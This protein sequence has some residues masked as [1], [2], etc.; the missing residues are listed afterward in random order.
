MS[1]SHL[2]KRHL[3]VPEDCLHV[4]F[5][6]AV[7]P[8]N[9]GLS[10][11]LLD[12]GDSPYFPRIDRPFRVFWKELNS[13][14]TEITLAFRKAGFFRLNIRYF[15]QSPFFVV[16]YN[17]PLQG[18]MD[19]F[20]DCQKESD[21]TSD[22]PKTL[23]GWVFEGDTYEITVPNEV[24]RKE[25]FGMGFES[26]LDPLRLKAKPSEK[27]NPL[28]E[29]KRVDAMKGEEAEIRPFPFEPEIG[30]EMKLL[31]SPPPSSAFRGVKRYTFY[32]G[33]EDSVPPTVFDYES[34]IKDSK[35]HLT[36]NFHI[37]GFFS[38]GESRSS[39]KKEGDW[40]FNEGLISLKKVGDQKTRILPVTQGQR[41]L[42]SLDIT[43]EILDP[44]WSLRLQ[45][46]PQ[47]PAFF[48]SLREAKT[49]LPPKDEPPPTRPPLQARLQSLINGDPKAIDALQAT[50]GSGF[51]E[52]QS[53][54]WEG[55]D[56]RPW[57][58][59]PPKEANLG[60]GVQE[61]HSALFLAEMGVQ[62]LSSQE[63]D[64]EPKPLSAWFPRHCGMAMDRQR[65]FP[66]LRY[67]TFAFGEGD[68][69]FFDA[70]APKVP[71]EPLI[72]P[73]FLEKWLE[74]VKT[75]PK[76]FFPPFL[77]SVFWGNN[78]SLPFELGSRLVLLG[79]DSQGNHSY[80]RNLWCIYADPTLTGFGI[81]RPFPEVVS[82]ELWAI[83]PLEDNLISA[84]K[85]PQNSV[86]S[87]WVHG[88]FSPAHSPGE[89]RFPPPSEKS[90]GSWIEDLE[91]EGPEGVEKH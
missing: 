41:V 39:F 9:K 5:F 77:S 74:G 61:A 82:L 16:K 21:E 47:H 67:V 69:K 1:L 79:K 54:P 15:F 60:F 38:L 51:F 86:A 53:P 3:S 20:G 17:S 46:W 19:I 62:P 58:P 73:A 43:E 31:L 49:P 84:L 71:K 63:P 22:S 11:F 59:P 24:A 4:S 37:A 28:D 33:L 6:L 30:Y 81:G 42:L 7:Q 8:S 2:Q 87:L 90:Q 40:A 44:R 45:F 83:T 72:T 91:S 14:F 66:F 29:V 27:G 34:E 26:I 89:L 18:A 75:P 88:E 85:R 68:D 23:F 70:A 76:A 55:V 52:V 80:M 35:I 12:V 64:N 57:Q 50:L 36:L 32:T 10:P 78:G 25:G 56:V 13:D 48:A 65:N